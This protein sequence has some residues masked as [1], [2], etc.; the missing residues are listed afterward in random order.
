MTLRALLVLAPTLVALVVTG[1]DSEDG[2]AAASGDVVD[3][4][5]DVAADL[6]N[7]SEHARDEEVDARSDSGDSGAIDAGP[8]VP[9]FRP[10]PETLG[11][12]A[13]RPAKVIVPD[14]YDGTGAW[15]VVVM[16]HGF[17]ANAFV[18]D[19]LFQLSERV[20]DRGF[21]LILPD[22]TTNPEGEQF[23]NAAPACCDFYGSGV[24]DVAYLRSL[25]EEAEE[26]MAIDPD[27]V[28]FVGH[29]NGGFMALRMA[30]DAA[31]VTHA[32]VSLAGADPLPLGECE[33][34]GPVSVLH[35]HGTGDEIIEYEGGVFQGG[36]YPGA[37]ETVARWV[38]RNGCAGEGEDGGPV[39][40][41]DRVEGAETYTTLW[42]ECD[43]A[44]RVGLWR[45]GDSEHVPLIND[46][47]REAVLDFALRAPV[48]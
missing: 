30:C 12:G 20:T 22:G 6:A 14:A 31:D 42:T 33:P 26:T 18:Q 4:A 29:S 44:A 41:D 36:A 23:W 17:S 19:A 37:E 8:D 15:P 34:S 38:V 32:A 7:D 11:E 5:A 3:A 40:Y 45:M 39:D 16:L 25:V 28:A 27:R 13:D 43:G 2:T 21:V 1:C 9:D 47:W 10:P 24:D 35:V 46:A 48:E